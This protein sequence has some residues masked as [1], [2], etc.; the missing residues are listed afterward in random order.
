MRVRSAVL[1]VVL[2]LLTQGRIEAQDAASSFD[3]LASARTLEQGD[4][5]VVTHVTGGESREETA[6]VVALDNDRIVLQID[7]QEI[8]LPEAAVS[9]IVRE[10]DSIWD[11]AR[12][13]GLIIGGIGLGIG[14]VAAATACGNEG[15]GCGDVVLAAAGIGAGLGF[16]TGL[17]LDA[18]PKDHT[19]LYEAPGLVSMTRPWV[20]APLDARDRR[21][22]FV[23]FRF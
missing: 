21:G 8:V 23:G 7:E 11:G 10:G 12:R 4:E 2:I 5:V 13:G 6:Q 20:V 17:A 1:L 16:L 9:T 18:T 15:G 3:A 19:T 22:L 14:A